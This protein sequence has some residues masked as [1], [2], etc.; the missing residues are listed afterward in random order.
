MQRPDALRPTHLADFTGQREVVG[1]LTMVL[2]AA[3]ERGELPDHLLFAGPAGLGKTTLAHIVAVELDLPMVVTSGPA[4]AKP[5]DLVSILSS[6]ARPTCFFVDEIHRMDRKVEEVLYSAMEDGVLDFMVGEG[7]KARA[8]RLPLEP[9]VLV[10]ATTQT[11]LL[12]APLRGRF[13]Y[14]ARM[15]LYELPELT[16]IVARSA[17]LVELN[18]T[19]SAAERV[20]SRGRGTPRIANMLLR[21][22][23]DW[24]QLG[25]LDV[26]DTDDAVAALDAFGIDEAGLD[27]LGV[28]ILRALC[29]TFGGGPVGVSTLAAAVGEAP[30][31]IEEVYEPYLMACGMLS[32]T[33]RG[34]VA[35][36]AAYAHLGMTPPVPAPG[37]LSSMPATSTGRPGSG[38]T[39]LALD[40][41]G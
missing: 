37:R 10:G 20:A 8:V 9:F 6:I 35:T 3:R 36:D 34:R 38:Q 25:G 13:G 19:A 32:R 26:I 4:L 27:S 12:S 33:P 22:V 2:D 28:D 7:A 5:S 31:S 17:K 18:L 15:R 29:V 1:H 23:R 30:S 39:A 40:I 14:T 41:A 16:S 21:R 24:A 11:G